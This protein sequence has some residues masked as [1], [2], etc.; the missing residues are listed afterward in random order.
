MD[1]G[2]A[3]S[4]IKTVFCLK[5]KRLKFRMINIMKEF[6]KLLILVAV[7]G[8]ATPL[9]TSC[10]D[11][12]EDTNEYT[13]SFVYLQRN[14]YLDNEKV[15]T[16][17]HNGI[18]GLHGEVMMPFRVKTQRAAS[19]DITVNLSVQTSVGIEDKIVLS[20][21]QVIIKAG[22]IQSEELTACMPDLSFMSRTEEEI[23]Y[24]FTV[25]IESIQST[26][27]N[28]KV[29][30]V[31]NGL[32]A[33]ITKRAYSIDNLKTGVPENSILDIRS[34]WSINV[35]EGVENSPSDLIDGQLG[36]DVAINNSGFW[37]I[38][39]LGSKK[40][41]TGI[42]TQHWSQSYAPSK[43]SVYISDDGLK[44]KSMGELNTSGGTQNISFKTSIESQFLK[45]EILKY[46][47][48]VDVTEFNVY[49]S[50]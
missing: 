38:V 23:D 42:K 9:I 43:I 14:D 19:A 11:S 7:I 21:Q 39:D 44:W 41:I 10:S 32:P 48:R 29:S 1:S 2:S 12:E 20:S 22:E 8:A 47:S 16:I 25:V 33:T 4:R 49:I 34:E 18:T 6:Y 27:T 46:P 3:L 5:I 45:Y 36:T 15:F 35:M 31:Y 40:N 30:S 17:I 50:K 37:I 13:T 26:D 24:T 28:V